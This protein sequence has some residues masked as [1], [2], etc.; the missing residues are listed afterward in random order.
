MIRSYFFCIKQRE[1][2]DNS[3][4]RNRRKQK[5]FGEIYRKEHVDKEIRN[6]DR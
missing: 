5:T 1:W 4:M 2:V 3:V 6:Y